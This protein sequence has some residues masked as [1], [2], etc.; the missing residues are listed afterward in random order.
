MRFR[1]TRYP[2]ATIAMGKNEGRGVL[3]NADTRGVSAPA[4]L[5]P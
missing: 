2:L 1:V 3:G 5:S 4:G